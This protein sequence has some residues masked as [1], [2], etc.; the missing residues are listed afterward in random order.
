M[1]HDEFEEGYDL[2]DEID[3]AILM[4]RDAH[5]GGDFQVML[6]YYQKD[7]GLGINPDFELD[8]IIY[9]QQVERELKTDLAANMLS[10]PEAEL[11]ARCRLAYERLKEVYEHK[12]L[13]PRLLADLILTEEHEPI[14]EIEAVAAQ[15]SKIVPELLHIIQSDD[16][17]DALFPGY[18]FAPYLAIICLGKIKDPSV[19]PQLF[20]IFSRELIFDEGVLLNAF[21]SIGEP[22]K[23]FLINILQGRPLTSDN[24]HAAFAL[25]AFGDDPEV[26]KLAV[27]QM[28]DPLVQKNELLMDYL[29]CH[30]DSPPKSHD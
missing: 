14:A 29:R 24:L 2:T 28:Q 27:D 12:M 19:L 7:E 1:N 30:T 5:F 8:R 10:A 11:V 16:A 17:Y 9:L 6:D 4:Q 21:V 25:T 20:G 15:G 3:H 23:A 13:L 18:G 22:A 26:V